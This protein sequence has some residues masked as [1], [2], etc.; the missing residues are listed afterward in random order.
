MFIK[1][2]DPEKILKIYKE[3]ELKQDEEESRKQQ[4]LKASSNSNL[5]K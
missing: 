4:E 3:G 1:Q 2:G 5:E